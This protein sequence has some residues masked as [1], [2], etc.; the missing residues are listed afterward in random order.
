MADLARVLAE[1]VPSAH[2]VGGIVRGS[3]MR[4]DSSDIDLALPPQDVKPAAL[5][6]AKKL[7]AAAFEMDAEFGVWRLVTH[8]DKVQIDLTAYQGKD[9]KADLLRRDFT[10]NSLAYPVSAVPE[11]QIKKQKDGT[12]KIRL[13]KLKRDLI[14]DLSG[15]LADVSAKVIRMNNP[16]VFKDDPLR[17]LRAFRSAA[18]LGF[19]IDEKTLKQIQKDA[20]LISQPAGERVQEELLRLFATS[21]AYE[22]LM[23]MDKYGLLTALFPEL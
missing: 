22:N 1:V 6:L 14:V 17:M 2:Y 5:A 15:G 11:I 23:L 18:E 21:K 13:T 4:K 16:R 10:F 3:L 19:S 9:L 8:K 20:A 7:K 12:A